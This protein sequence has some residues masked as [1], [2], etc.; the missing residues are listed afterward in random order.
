MWHCESE[1]PFSAYWDLPELQIPNNSRAGSVSVHMA[2]IAKLGTVH[3]TDKATKPIFA[4][5]RHPVERYR[6]AL[7]KGVKDESLGNHFKPQVDLLTG[8]QFKAYKFPE[9]L[10]QFGQDT[11]L[12]VGWINQSQHKPELTEAQTGSVLKDYAEDLKLFNSIEQPGKLVC[13]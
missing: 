4:L 10:A 9:H 7:A 13:L 12:N 6:S 3:G 5:I 2:I 1:A 11:G 8:H